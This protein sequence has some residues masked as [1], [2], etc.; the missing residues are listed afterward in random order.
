MAQARGY[1][2][3]AVTCD[4]RPAPQPQNFGGRSMGTGNGPG[5]G[6]MTA[7]QIAALSED[8]YFALRATP[9]GAKMIKRAMGG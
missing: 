5:G 2:A 3:C 9:E 1:S 4:N 8:D 7:A 6:S